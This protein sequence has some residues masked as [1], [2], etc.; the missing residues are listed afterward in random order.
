MDWGGGGKGD[1]V[2]KL[3]DTAVRHYETAWSGV[4]ETPPAKTLFYLP[5]V[6][7]ETESLVERTGV[8]LKKANLF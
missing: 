4:G 6:A 1:V 3:K 7:L 2:L 5:V 8:V